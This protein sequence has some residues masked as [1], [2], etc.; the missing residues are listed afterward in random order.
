MKATE[1]RELKLGVGPG[2]RLP[3]L[4]GERLT[5][6]VLTSVYLDTSD[7]RLATAGVTLRRRAE[8]G[9]RHWQLK[10]P[11]GHARLELELPDTS[12]GTGKRG[13]ARGRRAVDDPPA[14]MVDLV[15]AYT[16]G[17]AL[18]PVATL[19]S[20]RQG[21]MVRD[22]RGP[23]A[24]VVL[25]SVQVLDGQ[26]T[27]KRFREVEVEL[28][29]GDEAA[30]L[31]IGEMLRAAG[32]TDGDGRPKL[33]R[34]LG[35]VPAPPPA[36]P[37]PSAPP[38]EGLRAMIENQLGLI[39]A[40]D[41]GTRRGEDPEDLHQMRVA[42]RRLRA[43]LREAQPMLEPAWVEPLR[44]ELEWLGDELGAVRDLD[45]LRQHLSDEIATLDPADARGGSRLLRVLDAE[46]TRVRGGLLVALRSER[47]LTLL[48]LLD[49]AARQP[50]IVDV[51]ASLETV[52]RDAFKRLRRAVRGLG[53]EPSDEAL[54]DV[55]I[56]AKRAR[57]A[58]ELVAPAAGRLAERFIDRA[59]NF[60]DVLGEHQD[61]VVAQRRLR[62]LAGRARGAAVAFVAGRLLERQAA[63]RAKILRQF[64]K[65]WRKLQKRGLKAWH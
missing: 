62:E 6:R 22:F 24:E 28:T 15:T 46:R 29:G 14:E 42:C 32:A 49:E 12:S 50:H 31:R 13:R 44:D 55:R 61:A 53:E 37:E 25:D 10:L 59:K 23:V 60:Q 64:P 9:R 35:I 11:R 34:A 7:H 41:A 39:V 26:P 63:R 40:H 19:R 1:E 8:R 3:D 16:R 4:P 2:F 18:I 17:A 21:V 52:A 43:L 65:C 45:V 5:P 47:Y 57:Y 51:D 20:R 27:V 56:K 36:P 58:A 54:H 33:L 30:L 38:A 48:G